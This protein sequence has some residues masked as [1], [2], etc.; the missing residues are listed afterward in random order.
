MNQSFRLGAR[1]LP[2]LMLALLPSGGGTFQRETADPPRESVALVSA[3]Q[4]ERPDSADVAANK[5]A[6][7]SQLNN[8]SAQVYM[9]RVR[10]REMGGGEGSYGGFT[11]P[12]KM[13]LSGDASFKSEVLDS[14]HVRFTAV[15]SKGFGTITVTVNEFGVL[16]DWVYG[17]RFGAAAEPQAVTVERNRD[18]IINDFNNL[19]AFAYE[20][21]VR[22]RSL[23]GGQ[24]SYLG[25]ELP[26]Q[27]RSNQ[28]ATYSISGISQD[29]VKFMAVSIY[30]F[31][32]ITAEIDQDG[33]LGNWYYTD[34][35]R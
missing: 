15:S 30:G 8:L 32:V 18:A 4:Q 26:V 3:R 16:V 19:A 10:P 1:G 24:G 23:G 28:N 13:A 27:L 11:I 35:F 20:Y 29:M 21:R 34:K 22:P 33:R 14:A 2:T 7:I 31:G 12:P 5:E 9:Y 6:I 25:Y 17:G